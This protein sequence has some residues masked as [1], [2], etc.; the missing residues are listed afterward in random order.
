MSF[1]PSGPLHAAAAAAVQQ[2]ARGSDAGATQK[3]AGADGAI[4]FV[5]FSYE[6]QTIILPRQARDEHT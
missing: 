4:D 2:Q 1:A 5:S 6:R 3:P